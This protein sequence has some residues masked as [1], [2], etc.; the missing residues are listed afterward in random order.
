MFQPKNGDL[1][2]AAIDPSLADQMT[3]I[4][5][6]I[7]MQIGGE[8]LQSAGQNE[9]KLLIYVRPGAKELR[10]DC[11]DS[12]EEFWRENWEGDVGVAEEFAD[13]AG[14]HAALGLI[15]ARTQTE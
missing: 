15:R 4:Y 3:E 8:L 10:I 6:E 11:L 14:V 13:D 5:S 9:P 12:G 2:L 7:F 1:L